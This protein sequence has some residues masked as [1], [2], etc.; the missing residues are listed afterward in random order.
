MMNLK[1]QAAEIFK[2]TLKN[3]NPREFLPEILSWEQSERVLRVHNQEFKVP[4]ATEIFVIGTGKASPTMAS[5]CEN[6]LGGD[7]SGGMI[8]AP[9]DSKTTPGRITMLEGSHPLPD[10]QSYEASKR[11]IAFI[12]Q[13][14]EG[15]IV[16]NLLSGGTS[17]LLCMPADEIGIHEIREVYKLLLE[18][19]ATIHEVNTVRKAL[20]QVKGGKLLEHLNHTTLLDLVISDVPD[21]DL[22]YIGSGP[23]T[24]QEISY[25]DAHK[26][27]EKYRIRSRLP[28]S[29]QK[30]ISEKIKSDSVTI[31]KDFENHYAWIVSSASKVAER[32]RELLEEDGFKAELIH[33]A[34]TGIIDDFEEKIVDSIQQKIFGDKG[35]NA[36]VLYGE[37]TVKVT[38]EGLGGRN[39]ELALRLARRLT[40]AGEPI[41]FLSAGTDGIDGP[42]DAAGAVV[43]QNTW[44]EAK[45][46]GLDPEVFITENDSYHFFKKA[47]G[48]I[49]TGPTGNNVMD[50]Q[51]VLSN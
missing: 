11:L 44:R 49:I 8:I 24:A 34:W 35:K 38:G 4:P 18:S 29:V 26:V 28:E 20:S 7:L 30:R 15:S 2:S 19:G 1:K 25:T 32:T 10:E 3:V 37:C 13:I 33:P 46:A 43:D 50:I 40:D 16:I 27:V 17:S 47:G 42:T 12:D 31:T 23:T 21:D 36:L 22:R 51:I 14:P 41:A 6:V 5:A 39:Q 45:D 48:H 9:P